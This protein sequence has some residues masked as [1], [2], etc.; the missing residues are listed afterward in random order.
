MTKT[1]KN[2]HGLYVG[3]QLYFVPSEI[4]R[5]NPVTATVT[6][7]GRK[8]A[9]LELCGWHDVRIDIQTLRADGRGYTSPGSCYLSE[10]E[11]ATKR[12]RMY[13]WDSLKREIYSRGYPHEGVTLEDIRKAMEL[14][15]LS[16]APE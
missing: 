2:P 5:R 1:P 11:Y 3:Q 12:L 15:G 10:G 9:T 8:W 4:R 14:L 6:A 13:E 7:V 16:R